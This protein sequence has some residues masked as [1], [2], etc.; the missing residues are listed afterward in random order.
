MRLLLS[1]APA[2][3]NFVLTAL[4]SQVSVGLKLG[5]LA[6]SKF[7]LQN[8]MTICLYNYNNHKYI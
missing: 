5:K 1:Q 7:N 8:L 3:I 6:N 2:N 4:A